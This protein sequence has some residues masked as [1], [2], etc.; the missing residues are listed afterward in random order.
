MRIKMA[1]K[2]HYVYYSYEEWG[3][4]YIGKRSSKVLPEVDPYMGSFTDKTFHPT[5]KIVL[6]VFDTEKEALQAEILLHNFYQV[7]RNPHFANRSRQTSTGFTRPPDAYQSL[8][9]QQ[10]FLRNYKIGQARSI[11][12]KGFFYKLTGPD[13]VII[14]TLN[15]KS[16]CR[17]HGLNEKNLIQVL[18]GKRKHSLGWTICKLPLP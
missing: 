13:G 9:P 7:D 15:L 1:E 16:A 18:S 3:R 10:K 4:G 11:G 8:S 12:G 2:W 17:D 6:A 14:V 5:E